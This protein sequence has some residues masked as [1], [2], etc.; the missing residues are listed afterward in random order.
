MPSIEYSS[1]APLEE[2]LFTIGT[3]FTETITS[4][5]F[6][7]LSKVLT[8]TF[9]RAPEWAHNTTKA[10]A[11]LRRDMVAFFTTGTKEGRLAIS[12]PELAAAQFCGLIKEVVFWP[13]IMAGQGSAT[14]HERREAV[15]D[16]VAIF[17]SYYS[18][19]EAEAR[20]RP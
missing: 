2:Q 15:K 4:R 7:K 11:R 1:E 12:D 13:E 18:D 5:D 19:P 8:A 16:A 17:L 3:T 20:W 14:S 10:Y 9:I 6:M